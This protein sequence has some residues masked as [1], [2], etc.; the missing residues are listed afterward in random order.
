MEYYQPALFSRIVP[1]ALLFYPKVFS[2]RSV[3]IVAPERE[4]IN[5]VVG[6]FWRS[7]AA[8]DCSVKCGSSNA[9][10]HK[11]VDCLYVSPG[12]GTWI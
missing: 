1:N 12:F 9:T 7:N 11:R 10:I 5:A 6:H 8:K 4:G 3:P 2:V